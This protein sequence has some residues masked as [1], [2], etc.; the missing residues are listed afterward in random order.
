MTQEARGAGRLDPRRLH[1]PRWP[2]PQVARSDPM[3]SVGTLP[4]EAIAIKTLV[5]KMTRSHGYDE[6]RT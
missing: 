6:R 4:K 1:P 3:P 5:R 2:L